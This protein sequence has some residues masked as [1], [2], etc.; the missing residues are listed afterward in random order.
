M[1]T[2]CKFILINIFYSELVTSSS[3]FFYELAVKSMKYSIHSQVRSKI[4]L[5]NQF[6]HPIHIF[7]DTFHGY[8]AISIHADTTEQGY[9]YYRLEAVE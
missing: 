1:L 2:I 4:T 9:K 6:T 7:G 3:D 5:S 8:K